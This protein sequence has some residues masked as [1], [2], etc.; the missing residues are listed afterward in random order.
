MSQLEGKRTRKR[1]PR[2]RKAQH[3]YRLHQLAT[4]SKSQLSDSEDENK[5]F[6]LKCLR[7][8][9]RKTKTSGIMLEL[10]HPLSAFWMNL[11][12]IGVTPEETVFVPVDEFSTSVK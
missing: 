1:S 2:R 8:Y 6:H 4:S 11:K 9:S 3:L 12:G 7:L 5:L 10:M